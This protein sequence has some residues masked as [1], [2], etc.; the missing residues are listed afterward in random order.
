MKAVLD[1]HYENNKAMVSCV[2]F[3][4]WPDSKPQKIIRVVVP[5]MAQYRPGRFYER[6]L[7]C[8]MSVL[9]R[10]NQAFKTIVIDGYVHLMADI[11]KGLGV[12]LY[13][14]LPYS[15]VIVGVAKNPLKV[16]EHFLP[17]YRGR[18][19]KPLFVSAIGCP[20]EQAAQ[21]ILRM[22]GPYRIPTL[23][24]L[25]DQYARGI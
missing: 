7:P 20:V 12:H 1:A 25:A 17:I 19:R 3:D 13:E 9:H 4:S 18:S 8:L 6:E 11:G 14:S 22:H 10:A 2:I 24:K 5:C 21:S 23:V 16:A 15:S